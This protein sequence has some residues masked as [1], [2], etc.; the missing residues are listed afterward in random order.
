VRT[1]L[2]S[3]YDNGVD[4]R[5]RL[6]YAA[7][8]LF[9]ELGIQNTSTAAISRKA[10]VATGTLFNYFSSKDQLIEHLF[11]HA[12]ESM[13]ET[14]AVDTLDR[15]DYFAAFSSLWSRGITWGCENSTLFWFVEEVSRSAF[16]NRIPD[17]IH[18]LE[19]DVIRDFIDEGITR[20]IIVDVSV[21][22]IYTI[23]MSAISGIIAEILIKGAPRDE[24][25][26]H[27]RDIVWRA[28]RSGQT[29]PTC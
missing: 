3:W 26:A 27:S 5:E 8:E 14:T 23:V 25:I 19:H 16:R 2:P 18:W 21:D 7:A 20:G 11:H 10:G 9:T 1:P 28:L 4:K 6:L 24:M 17:S 29:D 12:T 13:I 15:S 22:L